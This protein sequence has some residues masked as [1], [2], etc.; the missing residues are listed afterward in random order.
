ME[1]A[2]AASGLEPG[3]LELEITESSVMH[4]P[5]ATLALIGRFRAMGVRVAMDDFGT[6]HSSLAYLRHFP[7]DKVKLDMAFIREIEQPANLAI[8]RAVTGIAES[9]A[10]GTTAEG[11]E[12]E[13]QLARVRRLG[14]DYVQGF[15]T[16]RP[17]STAEFASSYLRR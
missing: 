7:F 16:G 8:V 13:A 14:C 4:D 10:I 2:L 5:E 9:M 3:R 12:T 17:V 11:V 15:L 1:A 6:G